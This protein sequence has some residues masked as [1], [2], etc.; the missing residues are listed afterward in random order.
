ME[1]S[2]LPDKEPKIAILRKFD[3]LQGN[4]DSS[5]NQENNIGKK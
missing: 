4:T 2:N 1:S 3:E 5:T